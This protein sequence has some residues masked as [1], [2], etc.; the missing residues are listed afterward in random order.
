M[1]HLLSSLPLAALGLV[2]A[3][4]SATTHPPA[5]AATATAD[6]PP[7]AR[8]VDVV[9][10]QFGLELPDPYRWME[11][12]DNAEYQQWMIGQGD[13][14]RRQLDALPTLGQWRERLAETTR[15]VR[16]QHRHHRS[17]DQVFF[18]RREG[19]S[20]GILML[21]EVDGSERVLLDP[22]TLEGEGL[23]SITRYSVSPDGGRVALL[24]DRDGTEVGG[25]HILHVADARLEPAL[26]ER[27]KAVQSWLPDGS[28]VIYAQL[29]EGDDFIAHDP[30]Q[31]RR[32]RLHRFG[33]AGDDPVLL[34]SGSN[35]SLPLASSQSPRIDTFPHSG[36]V[37][38][39][40]YD[41]SPNA[42]L[43]VARLAELSPDTRWRCLAEK[44]DG[45]RGAE[46]SGDTLYLHS[47]KGHPNG[48]LLAL[49]LSDPD[50]TLAD[51]R[52]VL[53]EA[54]DA[55][56]S[57]FTLVRDALYVQ[58]MSNAINHLLRMPHD[59]GPIQTLTTP[60]TG[61]IR[62]LHGSPA[63]DGLLYASTNWF[64]PD[65]VFVYD[66]ASETHRDLGIGSSSPID[67]SGITSTQ[68]EAVSAD[69]TRVPVSIVHRAN[70]ALDGGNRALLRA[71][72]GYGRSIQPFFDPVTLEWVRAGNVYAIAHVRGGGEKG[73][74]W[75]LAGHGANKHK[76]VEDFLAAADALI[77]AGYTAR[78]RIALEGRSAGGLLIGGALAK[79]P[80]RFG[81]A[82]VNVPWVNPVR[83][84]EGQGGAAHVAESADPRTEEGLRV[85]AAMD[86]YINLREGASYP[87]VLVVVGFNDPRVATW[88]AGKFTARL[89]TLA[90]PGTPV[91]LRTQADSGHASLTLNDRVLEMADTFAFLHAHL[92][93]RE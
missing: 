20:S 68:I 5:S 54:P 91:W 67:T 47:T 7:I 1:K 2:L 63:Q 59:G 10:R 77:Q 75:R 86:P 23:A 81:A 32:V 87:P 17:G 72:G 65:T 61:T 78:E 73:E 48:R 6:A 31:N 53:P 64:T 55:V 90:A 70:I 71:Y 49:D 18:V 89:Q 82:L 52:E 93:G 14:A 39:A 4:C 37:L 41:T 50:A 46:V 79:A 58:R 29:A 8:T 13:Y 57:D 35:P 76:G 28:G 56:L 9:D 33:H 80:E 30:L 44:E 69:G 43:C 15:D 60:L 24:I 45:A 92:P 88:E 36:W 22:A 84:L 12:V 27:A 21:R 16:I 74:T 83:V 40:A 26:A 34:A 38:A 85:L 11:G 3:A 42:R 51:A 66:P 62:N 19:D 25:I